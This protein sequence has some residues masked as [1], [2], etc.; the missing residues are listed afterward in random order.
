MTDESLDDL[1]SFLRVLEHTFE[2]TAGLMNSSKYLI[3]RFSHV[4]QMTSP[5][6]LGAMCG[7]HVLVIPQKVCQSSFFINVTLNEVPFNIDHVD[8]SIHLFNSI[9]FPTFSPSSII[10]EDY[11][12]FLMINVSSFPHFKVNLLREPKRHFIGG[13][14]HLHTS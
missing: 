5:R 4:I 11:Y 12:L 13:M 8:N 9:H 10:S 7:A 6:K 3:S 14:T 2:I 1:G